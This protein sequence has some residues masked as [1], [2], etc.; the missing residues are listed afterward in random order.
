LNLERDFKQDYQQRFAPDLNQLGSQSLAELSSVA[1]LQRVDV[2]LELL[3]RATYY[4]IMAPLSAALRQAVLRAKDTEIDNSQTPE[5]AAL[6]SLT[7]LATEARQVLP[8]LKLSSFDQLA[9]NV[10]GQKILKQFDDLVELYGYLSEVGTDIAVPTWKED[11]Q[12]VR[13]LFV[14]L[15]ATADVG[16][17]EP[18][19]RGGRKGRK[20][21]GVQRRVDLKG[22][23]TEVYSQLLAQLR[24]VFCGVRASLV[25]VGATIAVWR[26]LFLGV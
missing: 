10:E 6:R 19:R 16:I 22:R 20:K 17:N 24:S 8:Q 15:V 2:I 25:T 13:E 9:E 3:K 18:Q 12:P 7:L 14:Q 11:P 21:R 23:V 1:L 26:Y 4:S 5:V